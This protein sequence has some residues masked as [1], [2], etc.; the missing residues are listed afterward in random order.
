MTRSVESMIQHHQN[1][2]LRGDNRVHELKHIGPW[3]Q[4]RIGGCR[5]GQRP[6][7]TLSQLASYLVQD[8]P[9]TG[10][11][12][13]NRMAD[14]LQNQ[15]PNKRGVFKNN[16][17]AEG[18]DG[19]Y[20]SADVNTMGYRSVAAFLHYINGIEGRYLRR[21]QGFAG[22]PAHLPVISASAVTRI[23]TIS[24]SGKYCRAYCDSEEGCRALQR[25]CRWVSVGGDSNCVPKNKATRSPMG[26]GRYQAAKGSQREVGGHIRAPRGVLIGGVRKSAEAGAP[27]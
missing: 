11:K 10:V 24:S 17:I 18:T 4:G 7:T 20:V 22:L 27:V 6:V 26:T 9:C 25:H 3:L 12:I 8:V 13:H 23:T 16:P 15:F 5:Y 14:M 1:S 21:K 19:L 2:G